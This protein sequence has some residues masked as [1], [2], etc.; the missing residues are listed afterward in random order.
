[1]RYRRCFLKRDT[2]SISIINGE[3]EIYI[4]TVF[5]LSFSP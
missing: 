3:I 5:S 4:E 2:D 1:M